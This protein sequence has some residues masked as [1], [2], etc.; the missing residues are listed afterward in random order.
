MKDP[1]KA[2]ARSP[3]E[4][5]NGEESVDLLGV[6]LGV[7]RGEILEQQTTT[8]ETSKSPPRETQ[9]TCPRLPLPPPPHAN[10]AASIAN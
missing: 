1:Q 6:L 9:L 5:R 2:R 7:L 8:E 4:E 10:Q 3:A